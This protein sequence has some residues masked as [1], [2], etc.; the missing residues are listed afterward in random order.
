MDIG[1][2]H[3]TID[4]DRPTLRLQRSCPLFS[5]GARTNNSKPNQVGRRT[6]LDDLPDLA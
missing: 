4:Q 1:S 2:I 6:S 5:L 3:Y